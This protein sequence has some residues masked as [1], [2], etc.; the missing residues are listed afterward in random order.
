MSQNNKNERI[1]KIN[2]L[3]LELD[4]EDADVFEKTMKTFEQMDEDG[5]NID[6]TG[7]MPEF[8]KRYCEIYYNAF[9]RIF[10][11]GTG[12]KIF[13]GKKNMRNCDEVW[14]SFLGF[15]QVAVKKANARRL[16]LSGKYMPNRDQNREQRRK[17]R[18]KNFNTYNGGKNR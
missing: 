1:W 8:I 14:D 17:K 15:M 13:N 5:R 4:L 6:K 18:K 7:K 11:E 12:E 9:D 2:G 3:E 10:G 16:Q